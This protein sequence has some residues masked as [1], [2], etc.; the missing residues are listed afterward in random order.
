[1]KYMLESDVG[2]AVPFSIKLYGEML[3]ISINIALNL[4]KQGVI[5]RI[6]IVCDESPNLGAEPFQAVAGDF[7]PA[8]GLLV[9]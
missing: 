1:M 6:S 4:R 3:S 9:E 7:L 5:L 2:F 8:A